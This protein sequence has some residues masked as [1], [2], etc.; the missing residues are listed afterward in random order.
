VYIAFKL[1]H[2][3][4]V[5]IFLGN[6]T[7]GL[8]WKEWADRTKDPRIIAHTIDGIIRADRIF[9]I[10]SIVFL[11]IGG[12]GAALAG[13]IPI[14]STGWILWSIVLFII[15]G[16]AFGPVARAQRLLSATAHEGVDSGT[17]SAELYARFSQV[18][19][20]WGMI[21][22]LAPAAAAVLMIVKP[23]LPAFHA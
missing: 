17:M 16:A 15:A 19:N 23:A 11:L 4:A 9:T 12:I 5:I 14:L 10:P 13:N 20:F 3:L 18:W 6:I 1:L 8:F 7:V 22:L 2:V 21:A